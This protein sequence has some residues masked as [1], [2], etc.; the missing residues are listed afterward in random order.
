MDKHIHLQDATMCSSFGEAS[1][2]TL[3]RSIFWV[4]R[5]VALHTLGGHH[6]ANMALCVVGGVVRRRHAE[7]VFKR[8]RR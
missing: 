2:R 7:R 5:P 8:V 3:T 6:M 4:M 1:V